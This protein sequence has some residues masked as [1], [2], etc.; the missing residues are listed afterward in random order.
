MPEK[1][2]P[3]VPPTVSYEQLAGILERI[4][5]AFLALD[6]HWRYIYVNERAAQLLLRQRGELIGNH[7]LEVFPAAADYPFYF[8]YQKA[9]TE[10]VTVE[11][12]DYFP[13]IDRWFINRIH[14]SP[15]GI[16]VFLQDIT[17]RKQAL[18][19]LRA[20][21][22]RFAKAFHQNPVPMAITRLSD[23]AL[24]SANE[25]ALRFYGGVLTDVQGRRTLDTGVWPDAQAYQRI[26]QHFEQHGSLRNYEAVLRHK[27][28]KL[29]TV[30]LSGDKI[31][32]DDTPCLITAVIDITDRKEALQELQ[33]SEER[34]TKAFH[35][36]PVPL[37]ISRFSDRALLHA[38][39]AALQFYGGTLQDVQ[40]RPTLEAGI[41]PNTESYQKTWQYLEEH[42]SLRDKETTMRRRDGELRTV[43]LSCDTIILNNARCMI[44]AAID[45]TG[46]KQAETALQ[47][48]ERELAD[49]QR[50]AHVGSWHWDLLNNLVVWS[51]ELYR[52][53]G[54]SPTT[55]PSPELFRDLV[56]PQDRARTVAVFAQ[57]PRHKQPFEVEFRAQRPDG[58]VRII[59]ATG[60][61]VCNEAG[62]AAKMVGIGRD[63]TVQK[64]AETAL[65]ASENKFRMMAE[66]TT[67][68]IYIYHPEGRFL[69]VN[70]AMCVATGYTR[71]QLLTQTVWDLTGPEFHEQLKGRIQLCLNQA[72]LPTR[73]EIRLRHAD[74]SSRW[75]LYSAGQL[76]EF[77]G[78]PAIIGTGLDVTERRLNE[79]ALRTS[80]A[81]L[82][83]LTARLQNLREE[84]S[85]RIAREIHDE[86]GSALTGLKWDAESLER[87][88]PTS[89]KAATRALMQ[90][91][92]QSMKGLVDN[93]VTTVRRISAELRPRMLDD[94]GLV[95]ALEWQAE[96]F[97]TR[98]GIICECE[99][100]VHIPR[101]PPFS[102]S[103]R[104]F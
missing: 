47:E 101:P 96:Q 53:Y 91:K 92:I 16:S 72:I 22:E 44:T 89:Q 32:L 90:G 68:A 100:A 9:L 17:E 30:L 103:F 71:E 55:K 104:K 56:H 69:Y 23:K 2:I 85:A 3:P 74:G 46:R 88:I 51:D 7:L 5:D 21:E 70:P 98:T 73:Q 65:R 11:F 31:L 66:S 33:A 14:P 84:E 10:Q 12:E 19:E 49:A 34:F 41:W 50:I 67:A 35:Q 83:A 48:R 60:E 61:V 28:G 29:R 78:K 93:T 39:E 79:E 80:R 27:D 52:I 99:F 77:E 42:G 45:I 20:S 4:S 86:L 38:N 25:A 57:A 37:V 102:A 97:Q 18:Q 62:Q 6:N 24:L 36:N 95:A 75:V 15:D 63:I 81:Q 54:I 8:H 26:W 87:L 43:L 40:G 58:T 59:H 1:T 13:H 94:L 76:I 82:R 64:Q